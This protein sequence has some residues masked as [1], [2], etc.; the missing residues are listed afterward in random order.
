MHA[1]IDVH[2]TTTT[3]TTLARTD[4]SRPTRGSCFLCHAENELFACRTRERAML[5]MR[6]SCGHV[7][8]LCAPRGTAGHHSSRQRHLSS[9]PDVDVETEA[10]AETEGTPRQ[11][12]FRRRRR[13]RRSERVSRARHRVAVIEN[14]RPSAAFPF[15]PF[16]LFPFS[17]SVLFLLFLSNI[18]GDGPRVMES[19][20]R[21]R[22]RRVPFSTGLLGPIS[23]PVPSRSTNVESTRADPSR[24]SHPV[25]RRMNNRAI[26]DRRS[27]RHFRCCA[28]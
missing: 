2:T 25:Q 18:A 3:T 11:G 27:L 21:A 13:R 5:P 10:I 7:Y 6:V 16:P 23:P 20:T 9:E 1:R 28:T 26:T 4:A 14:H 8:V 15:S 12:W 22:R 24:V 17:L 19:R